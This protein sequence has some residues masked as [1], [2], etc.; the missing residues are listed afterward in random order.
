MTLAQDIVLVPKRTKWER[1]L[2]RYGSQEAALSIYKHQNNAYNS[3][4]AAHQRQV[5]NLEKIKNVLPSIQC[6]YRKELA[7][8]DPSRLSLLIS[9]GG[10]NHFIYVAHRAQAIPIL[11]LNSDPQ[12]STGALLYFTPEKF[13]SAISPY[14]QKKIKTLDTSSSLM[15]YWT[16]VEGELILP[17]KNKEEKIK[18]GPCISEISVR[19]SFHDYISRFLLR[20]NNEDWEELKCSGL[21]LVSGAGSSGWYRNAHFDAQNAVFA[22]E[23]PF[24][25]ALARETQ[26]LHR[27]KLSQIESQ[28]YEKESLEIISEMN[29]EITIDANAEQVYPFPPGA[30]AFF[31]L[32]S[33][34]LKVIRKI[35]AP[36]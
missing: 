19:S 7:D 32:S 10:D 9:F 28:I 8:L 18:L 4:F 31:F 35:I 27:K 16:G 5:E 11:G 24:F 29:G 25:R 21:L 22:K 6:V 30:R 12:S 1:D 20:K 23:A 36:P 15:E 34:K 14:I 26:Y 2:I 17:V 3:V 13:I 33:Q